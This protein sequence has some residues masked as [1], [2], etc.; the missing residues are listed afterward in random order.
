MK[1]NCW[2]SN[3]KHLR[4]VSCPTENTFVP[5]Q[6]T[7]NN[8]D[9]FLVLVMKLSLA[10]LQ[11]TQDANQ[12]GEAICDIYIKL[13]T[14][15]VRSQKDLFSFENCV[16][17]PI[18]T[19]I[20]SSCAFQCHCNFLSSINME[21]SE[22]IFCTKQHSL[23]HDEG[24]IHCLILISNSHLYIS[25]YVCYTYFCTVHASPCACVQNMG[26][27]LVVFLFLRQ[28]L[29]LNLE[30]TCWLDWQL[31]DSRACSAPATSALG[32]LA[33][34]TFRTLYELSPQFVQQI[35]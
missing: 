11:F 35:Y 17:A 8:W 2:R 1:N 33:F 20:G 26:S 34:S 23:S 6:E 32:L 7:L 31:S 16:L 15:L 3:C 9:C 27:M 12:H 14:T 18:Q 21:K 19:H 4:L 24:A 28:D 13:L 29:L 30:L 10:V 22:N 25:L 5:S